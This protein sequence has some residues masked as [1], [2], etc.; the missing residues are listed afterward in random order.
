MEEWIAVLLFLSLPAFNFGFYLDSLCIT[1]N[2]K[3]DPEGNTAFMG[4]VVNN[5]IHTTRSYRR[6][7][8][9]NKQTNRIYPTY[10]NTSC[11]LSSVITKPTDELNRCG[12]FIDTNIV[13]RNIGQSFINADTVILTNSFGNTQERKNL[14]FGVFQCSAS[15]QNY[16]YISTVSI[17]PDEAEFKPPA[18]TITANLDERVTL[19]ML[20]S[21]STSTDQ[22]RW[23][24]SWGS[25]TRQLSEWNG[26]TTP[27]I[28]KVNTSDAGVYEAYT[29]SSNTSGYVRLIVRGCRY[30]LWGFPFCQWTCPVCY[31]GGICD[32]VSGRCV[33]PP[34]FTGGQCEQAC[35]SGYIG[36]RCGISC[37]TV[38]GD[39]D[40]RGVE[41]CL[42][43]PF[44][45]SCAPGFTGLDCKT[46]CTE[47][48]YGAGCTSLCH[49]SHTSLCDTR[50]GVCL[51]AGCKTSWSGP[52]C[53]A[54][55]FD[56]IGYG[57]PATIKIGKTFTVEGLT[58]FE[59]ILSI[60]R[61]L[62]TGREE[63]GSGLR[64]QDAP[65]S[66]IPPTSGLPD[67]ELSFITTNRSRRLKLDKSVSNGSHLG[68]YY[69]ELIEEKLRQHIE[70]LKQSNKDDS[71]QPHRFTWSVGTGETVAMTV[72][73]N[74]NVSTLRWRHNGREIPLAN[75]KTELT[76][77]YARKADEGVYE[78]FPNNRNQSYK[79]FMILKVRACPSGFW[80][81]YC[82]NT[83]PVCY[84][85][86]ICHEETGQCICQAGYHGKDC[87]QACDDR[88]NA[89]G[90]TCELNCTTLTDLGGKC[91]YKQVCSPHP[92]GCHCRAGFGSVPKCNTTCKRPYFG[93]DCNMTANCGNTQHD[94]VL[95]CNSPSCNEGYEGP[96]CQRLKSSQSCP[97]GYYG[98][99]CNYICHCAGNANC[100][101]STGSC[102]NGGCAEGW[103]GPNCQDALPA[104]MDAPL[105]TVV[106]GRTRVNW[107]FWRPGY[108]YG[109]GPVVS[110]RVHFVWTND[111]TEEL[112]Y[113]DTSDNYLTVTGMD[114][115]DNY[116]IS[117]SVITII[118][119]EKTVG[120]YS[121]SVVVCNPTTH[122]E[123]N[124]SRINNTDSGQIEVLWT[125]GNVSVKDIN[126]NPTLDYDV[127]VR[128]RETNKTT[129]E[130]SVAEKGRR[131]HIISNLRKCT[132][133]EVTVT[134][135]TNVGS[136]SRSTKMEYVT[137]TD[138]IGV[139]DTPIDVNTS[140]VNQ[141]SI[142]LSWQLPESWDYDCLGC[143][144]KHPYQ[145]EIFYE[146]SHD[147]SSTARTFNQS[148][149]DFTFM[150]L[151][152]GTTYTFF[153][154]VKNYA[155][156]SSQPT[157]IECN[158][159]IELTSQVVLGKTFPYV[160]SIIPS[161]VLAL[162]VIAVLCRRM[163]LLS[164][165][166]KKNM[167]MRNDNSKDDSGKIHEELSEMIIIEE[168]SQSAEELR[169][170]TDTTISLHDL[171]SY[172][173]EM[174]LNE[175]GFN[176]EFNKLIQG[177]FAS[178]SVA[179]AKINET[180]NRFKNILTYD[181][182]RVVLPLLNED[183]STDYINASYIH[184]Y[185]KR[186]A[187]IASQGPNKAS[188]HDFWRMIWHEKCTKIVMVTRPVENGKVKCLK[189]WP[190]MGS[191]PKD[192]LG[193]TVATIDEITSTDL[194]VR[195]FT[196]R[197]VDSPIHE[198]TQYHYL[199]WP[200]MK[201]PQ[202]ADILWDII[203]EVEKD[204]DEN[205]PP[206][207]VHCSAGCG[208]TGTVI[209][210]ASLRKMMKQE[211]AID[212]F[213]FVNNMRKQRPSMV[214]VV[215][216]YQF[217]FETVLIQSLVGKSS[218]SVDDF[219]VNLNK[220]NAS[221][222]TDI[223]RQ[224]NMLPFLNPFSKE[225]ENQ[226]GLLA[227]NIDKN[228]NRDIIPLNEFRPRLMTIVED[229]TATDY[230]NASFC[231]GYSKRDLFISTQLP[232]PN[233]VVDFWRMVF[234][235]R[236]ATI[237]TFDADQAETCLNYLPSEGA[238][239]Y[240]PFSVQVMETTEDDSISTRKVCIAMDH[241]NYQNEDELRYVTNISLGST[242][243]SSFL[244]LLEKVQAIQLQNED[245]RIVV[246][247]LDGVSQ[248]GVFI[249][250]YNCCEGIFVDQVIDLFT[251]LRKLRDRR[252]EM[253]GT[254]EQYAFCLE[255]LSEKLKIPNIYANV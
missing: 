33:C 187:F 184:G 5:G 154:T 60:G 238:S 175:D 247:C 42:P 233:T 189:Y 163:F 220:W 212:V 72:S 85:Q 91:R 32:D 63:T 229:K 161:L 214:Q 218:S 97:D 23:R 132:E 160:F 35:P 135:R 25:V 122:I 27:V 151:E 88:S 131:H 86:G 62:E 192:F 203:D 37:A 181:H 21:D 185:N 171:Q 213:N 169:C 65:L 153:I 44:G 51:E 149:N 223:Q 104:L 43:H 179:K 152:P 147:N 121:P 195:H 94:A 124:V 207:V 7:A 183:S 145:F 241:Q 77:D 127:I 243:V 224:F 114:L 249:A 155:G 159:T 170:R 108:D 144:L 191:P 182:S 98:I 10:G 225:I 193:I 186:N 64:S 138:S 19:K 251:V 177:N 6:A 99:L 41:I 58:T 81:I 235:Y 30:N 188:L 242:T 178:C 66:N 80:G 216:Q 140:D 198:V 9:T 103:G 1:A 78:C 254:M 24:Y 20:A 29:N 252:P 54:K 165:E 234:D 221:T 17:I 139:A 197:I 67:G 240:G 227:E 95:G 126:C 236:V 120:Q 141:T 38:I 174:K 202:R 49:C 111:F 204:E 18:F 230:I 199:G 3:G 201:V 79:G 167:K 73:Y 239:Q 76:I 162:L 89:I 52:M 128:Y 173:R 40:C 133:Y 200:D 245:E 31:N 158:T 50:T 190:D 115:I 206:I 28:E 226:A 150:N 92:V 71:V 228:R 215:E 222:P 143:D 61:E 74:G 84:Y 106:E 110:Y 87:S 209:A 53:Q 109:T 101:R 168:R 176:V 70:I 118:Q 47:G 75:G 102:G 90:M 34:G 231:D 116:S 100:N 112:T 48:T 156:C 205:S 113:K 250:V 83:C 119:D 237:V 57:R 82:N 93:A 248:C 142:K 172:V 13:Q 14:R 194:I 166:S 253:V 46:D 69:M 232:L 123:F 137:I 148:Q 196:L 11:D 219:H 180:K 59:T 68:V 129:E 15:T 130:T 208:R 134:V 96:G 117:V 136:E 146:S 45:C 36:R 8:W 246:Q 4:V 211:R 2:P 125:T 56:A 55:V 255:V 210:L 39:A 22:V 107:K 12:F 157:T 26:N 105:V 16:T 164:I 217:I 244:S